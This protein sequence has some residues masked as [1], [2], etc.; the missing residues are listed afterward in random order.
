MRHELRR[1]DDILWARSTVRF[2]YSAYEIRRV[3]VSCTPSGDYVGALIERPAVD[4]NEF[5]G[6]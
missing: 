3:S 5:A 6:N 2:F 4:F 1:S